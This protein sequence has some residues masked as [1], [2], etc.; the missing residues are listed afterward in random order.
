MTLTKTMH[1]GFWVGCDEKNF[2]GHVWKEKQSFFLEVEADKDSPSNIPEI[3]HDI[4]DFLQEPKNL[5][6]CRSHDPIIHLAQ[7]APTHY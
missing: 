4:C 6:L 7:I 3:L 1:S 5:P 2:K